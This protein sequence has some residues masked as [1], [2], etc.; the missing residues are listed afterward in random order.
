MHGESG[1]EK[2]HRRE[3]KEGTKLEER[4]VNEEEENYTEAH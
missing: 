1:K 2:A 4:E 3:W